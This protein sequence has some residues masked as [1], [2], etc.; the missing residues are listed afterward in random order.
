VK[1]SNFLAGNSAGKDDPLFLLSVQELKRIAKKHNKTELSDK[2]LFHL[3]TQ[4]SKKEAY[5]D[6]LREFESVITHSPI[7]QFDMKSLI[8][9]GNIYLFH[10]SDE[11]KAE[12][13]FRKAETQFKNNEFAPETL[14]LIAESYLKMMKKHKRKHDAYTHFSTR[15]KNSPEMKTDIE[16][17]EKKAAENMQKAE[18]YDKRV[19]RILEK[20][21]AN[22]P[23]NRYTKKL[24]QLTFK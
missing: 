16:V 22:Y 12:E 4:Y 11:N 2:I 21:T 6:A 18:L 5:K 10:L 7:S 13:V 17:A 20:L 15:W 9:M 19:R 14:Y 8:F 24:K 23:D 3:G 1:F